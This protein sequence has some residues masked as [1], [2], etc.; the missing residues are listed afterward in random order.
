MPAGGGP[1]SGIV[2][3]VP[4]TILYTGKGGVG[5]TSVA[6]ATGRSIAAAA[7]LPRRRPLVAGQGVRP[8]ACAARRGAAAR[9]RVPGRPAARR[10][11]VHGGPGADR[12][13][14]R[15]E[16]DPPRRRADLAAAR[17]DAG[18]HGRQ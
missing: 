6:A 17:D 9:A 11:R 1:P 4:R 2:A 7:L 13:P 15:D 3:V 18:P 5:K 12:Q 16:R 10:A 8:R 14:R